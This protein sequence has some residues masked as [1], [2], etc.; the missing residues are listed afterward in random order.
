VNIERFPVQAGMIRAWVHAI[1]D[2]NPVYSDESAAF[3]AGLGGIAAPPTFLQ[4]AEHC[5]IESAVRPMPGPDMAW[6]R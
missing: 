3:A 2:D 6:L 1:D 5:A 4:A